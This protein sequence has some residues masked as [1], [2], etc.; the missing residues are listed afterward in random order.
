ML[1][2]YLV[3]T[4]LRFENNRTLVQQ[5]D[6]GHYGGQKTA[7]LKIP[8]SLP[9]LTDWKHFERIDGQ[10]EYKGEYYRLVQKT[11][12]NDTLYV[13][14]ICNVQEKSIVNKIIDFVKL[15]I[16]PIGS[17]G[18][19]E[20]KMVV[21]WIKDFLP[22]ICSMLSAAY[23]APAQNLQTTHASSLH[24]MSYPVPFPPPKPNCRPALSA[25]S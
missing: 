24:F 16:M 21:H 10:F 20:G 22:T 1:G 18:K 3:L 17:S 4:I 13:E 15:S 19:N 9:Y 5:L 25:L 7:W 6:E 12:R 2:H 14:Y 23:L 11:L 8:L